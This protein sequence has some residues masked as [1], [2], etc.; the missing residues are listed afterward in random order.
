MSPP[1]KPQ[2]I[3]IMLRSMG[4]GEILDMA[5]RLAD[6]GTVMKI[7]AFAN[8]LEALNAKLETVIDRLDR[9][10]ARGHRAGPE[11]GPD[12]AD[13]PTAGGLDAPAPRANGAAR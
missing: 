12:P 1:A 9:M 3:E 13:Q 2:G 11:P 4:M 7:L 5:R 6:E 10:E 8:G